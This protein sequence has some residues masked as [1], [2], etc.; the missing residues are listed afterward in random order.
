[1]SPNGATNG[2][3]NSGHNLRQRGA[4]EAEAARGA[5]PTRARPLRASN[6]RCEGGTGRATTT[7]TATSAT[8]SAISI[9]NHHPAHTRAGQTQVWEEMRGLTP[10]FGVVPAHRKKKLGY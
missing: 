4:G 5:T 9:V 8:S 6:V 7:T 3:H 10:E 1:M 2:T